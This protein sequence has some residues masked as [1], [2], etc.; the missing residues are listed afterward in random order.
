MVWYTSLPGSSSWIKLERTLNWDR[1]LSAISKKGIL[2]KNLIYAYRPLL[3]I[4][5]L[6]IVPDEII[7]GLVNERVS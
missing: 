1:P 7:R 3:N 6:Y 2:V 5:N 4:I